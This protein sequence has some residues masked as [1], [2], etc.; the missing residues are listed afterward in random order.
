MA[1]LALSNITDVS[2]YSKVPHCLANPSCGNDR[3]GIHMITKTQLLPATND[4][5][6]NINIPNRYSF[7]KGGMEISQCRTTIQMQN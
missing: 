3:E 7:T 5:P 1:I 6:Y 2:Y 4:A